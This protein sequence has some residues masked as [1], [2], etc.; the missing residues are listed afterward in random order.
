MTLKQRM[1]WVKRDKMSEL[2]TTVGPW[3][4][5]TIVSRLPRIPRK[6]S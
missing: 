6:R 3:L 5:E 2:T 4:F 1:G